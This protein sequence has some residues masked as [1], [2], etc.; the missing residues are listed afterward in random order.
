M[1]SMRL[2]TLDKQQKQ[3]GKAKATEQAWGGRYLERKLVLDAG[4][5]SRFTDRN[6]G[7]SFL[8]PERQNTSCA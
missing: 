8:T 4:V 5:S 1:N 2:L 7:L 6:R 3:M